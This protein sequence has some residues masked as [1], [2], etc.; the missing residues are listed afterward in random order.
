MITKNEYTVKCHH[1]SILLG[2]A[3]AFPNQTSREV[4]LSLPLLHRS[5]ENVLYF[6]LD[7]TLTVVATKVSVS[8]HNWR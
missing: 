5:A 2:D 1:P 3:E 8:H 7:A 4:K 6:L